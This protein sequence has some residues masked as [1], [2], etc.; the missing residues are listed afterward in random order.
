M[1]TLRASTKIT[2]RNIISRMQLHLQ[3][4]YCKV[5][6]AFSPREMFCCTQSYVSRVNPWDVLS[7]THQ[8]KKT[9]LVAHYFMCTFSP[10]S[11]SRGLWFGITCLYIYIRMY[12]PTPALYNEISPPLYG[13]H[14]PNA[15]HAV[16]RK[17]NR[18]E[19][20]PHGIRTTWYLEASMAYLEIARASRGGNQ[21]T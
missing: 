20:P 7:R 6:K 13:I 5:G 19:T 9:M 11:Q 8:T 15:Q 4:F 3:A 12:I 21:T 17:L 2:R 1:L 18:N 14:P 10:K 16:H